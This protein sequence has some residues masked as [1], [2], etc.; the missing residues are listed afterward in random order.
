MC[1]GNWRGGDGEPRVDKLGTW[2]KNRWGPAVMPCRRALEIV[3][4]SKRKKEQMGGGGDAR[5]RGTVKPRNYTNRRSAA[6]IKIPKPAPAKNAVEKISVPTNE[7]EKREEKKTKTTPGALAQM[8]NK[9][10]GVQARR[11]LDGR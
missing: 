7:E 4:G 6:R 1:C 11:G 10:G 9:G 3:F 5:Q 8:G 2:A